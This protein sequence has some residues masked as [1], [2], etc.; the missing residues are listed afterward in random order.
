MR[1]FLILLSLLGIKE[2]FL[3]TPIWNLK[4]TSDDLLLNKDS[5]TI[6]LSEG[7]WKSVVNDNTLVLEKQIKRINN[8]I[9]QKNYYKIDN[10]EKKE[11]SWED[12][13]SFYQILAYFICPKGSHYLTQ[14][15]DGVLHELK[16]LDISGEWELLCFRQ[17][18]I[19][20]VMFTFYFNS[21]LTKIYYYKYWDRFGDGIEINRSFLD[22][23]WTVTPTDKNEYPMI[24]LTLKDNK[25]YI[26][27]LAIY[28]NND[29]ISSKDIKH[30]ELN[31]NISN[32]EAQFFNSRIFFISYD[33]SHF[34]SG[35][36]ENGI[37]D[38]VCGDISEYKI[39][40]NI[41]SPF[42]FLDDIKIKYIKFIRNTKYVYYNIITKTNN[43]NY[44]GVIDI[45]FNRVIYNVENIFKEIKPYTNKGL[46]LVTDTTIYR[47]CFSGKDKNNNCYLECP[48]GQVLV[49]DPIN[50]NYCSEK[51][52]DDYYILKPDD[53]PIANCNESLYVIQNKNECGLCKDLNKDK[54]YKI[55]DEK[56]CIEKP[57]NTYY[58]DEQL[59]ILNYCHESCK[60]CKGEK[61]TDCT[62]CYIGSKLVN[63]KCLKLDCFH[64]CKECDEESDN[65][66]NQHCLSCKTNKLFQEDNHNCIDKCLDGYY[67]DNN[68][69]RVC[70]K[71]CLKCEKGGSEDN[72]NCYSCKDN[73]YLL[74]DSL[75]CS[76][77]CGNNYYK[78]E[79]EKKCY[80]CSDNCE[81][82][83]RGSIDGNNFCLTCDKNSKFK[84]L[85]NQ[86]NISNCVEECPNTTILNETINQCIEIAKNENDNKI[87]NYIPIIFFILI[88]ILLFI[89]ILICLICICN[90]KKEKGDSKLIDKINY[91]LKD[92][93]ILY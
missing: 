13:E 19:Q 93:N 74:D 57:E 36:S 78:N 6:L 60:S 48:S 56:E 26:S 50:S 58:I 72:P 34:I 53:I 67:E 59:K 90:K 39:I 54:Q 40:K 76:E 23:M 92:N 84:Y 16:P 18:A 80:R 22:L 88:I 86:I 32:S 69:C 3:L 47:E 21:K 55:I 33:E 29:K 43:K 37:K 66:N 11:T 62:S 44:I 20:N 8:K 63:G 25:I 91:E 70:H 15:I 9:T 27:K 4:T 2:I 41:K 30:I 28:V 73:K 46:F 31:D 5:V 17:V 38:G 1:F 75:K 12:I 68:T 51:N 81:K 64:S 85:L 87:G 52:S 49:L 42:E 77:N 83:S 82:C 65:E 89:M 71:S 14:Y 35:F 7:G 61:E 79:T 24:A 10:F 45:Q